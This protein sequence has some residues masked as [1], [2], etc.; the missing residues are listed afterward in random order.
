M[1]CR[2]T[3]PIAL[4]IG[5]QLAMFLWLRG[6]IAD[7]LAAGLIALLSGLVPLM[8]LLSRSGLNSR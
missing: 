3:F 8:A 5:F 1:R 4:V 2:T 6:S 7:D